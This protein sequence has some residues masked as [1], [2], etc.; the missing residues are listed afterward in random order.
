MKQE[1]RRV[2]LIHELRL[3]CQKLMDEQGH[4]EETGLAKIHSAFKHQISPKSNLNHVLA[5]QWSPD[6]KKLCTRSHRYEEAFLPHG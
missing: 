2:R 3:A 6:R 5:A 4:K 1:E